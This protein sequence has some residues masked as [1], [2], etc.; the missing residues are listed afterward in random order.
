MPLICILYF[1]I[2][3]YIQELKGDWMRKL[4]IY[5]IILFIA[6][7]QSD[8]LC[9]SNIL[10]CGD[11]SFEAREGVAPTLWTHRDN[12]SAISCTAFSLI[13]LPTPIVTLFKI[14]K[15]H[16]LFGAPWII[17]GRFGY[18]VDDTIQYY[19]EFN[20]R[21]AHG[22]QFTAT[23]R[24][25]NAIV[26]PNLIDTITFVL[27]M[28]K[29]SAFDAYAG[30]RY[31]GNWCGCEHIDW[32]VGGKVGILHRKKI[33]FTFTTNSTIV[34][35]PTGPFV[36][37]ELPFFLRNNSISGGINLGFITKIG[38]KVNLIFTGELV[39]AC[40]PKVNP[41]IQFDLCT[42]AIAINP[43]LVPNAF[44]I[45]SICT[46]LFFPITIGLEYNF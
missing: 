24:N 3:V 30:T 42:T 41:A 1:F 44:T 14:P 13:G 7:C 28:K 40:G 5:A 6:L 19:L 39:A 36:S 9:D 23:N 11:F 20:Y 10:N 46:E 16:N 32:F 22:K 27:S 15:F 34:P 33:N 29:Y 21:Q 26:L 4:I 8:A 43:N 17:G 2:L 45:G 37:Q 35:N 38:C 12:F 18:M 31:Y 25:T